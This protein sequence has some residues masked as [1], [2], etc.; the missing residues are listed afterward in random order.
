[1]QS[2]KFEMY[3]CLGLWIKELKLP[4]QNQEKVDLS[5]GVSNYF[6]T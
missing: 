6:A 4:A 3:E 5:D 2:E 1:M